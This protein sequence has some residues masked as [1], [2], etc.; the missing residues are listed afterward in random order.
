MMWDHG[1][2]SQLISQ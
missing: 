1:I 2:L